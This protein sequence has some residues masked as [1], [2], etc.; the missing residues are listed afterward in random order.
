M[1]S[2]CRADLGRELCTRALREQGEPGFRRRWMFGLGR[3][4]LVMLSTPTVPKH[5][6]PSSLQ[7]DGGGRLAADFK[8]LSNPVSGLGSP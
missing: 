1:A 5:A 6:A 8:P 2:A 4:R 7:K 3:I